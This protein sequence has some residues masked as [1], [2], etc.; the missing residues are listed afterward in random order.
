[1]PRV[2]FFGTLQ[3]EGSTPDSHSTPSGDYEVFA[4]GFTGVDTLRSPGNADHRPT[5]LDVGPDG[6]LYVS[7]DENGTIWRIAYVGTER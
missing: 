5:G 4:D 3:K 7:D 2:E 1:M 6:G